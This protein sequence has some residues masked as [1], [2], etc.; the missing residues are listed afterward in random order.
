MTSGPAP[1]LA[2]DLFAF[3]LVA[4]FKKPPT[5][6]PSLVDLEVVVVEMS[7]NIIWTVLIVG[8]GLDFLD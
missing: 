4:Q 7:S 6:S 8:V 1:C 3:K 5:T 2:A